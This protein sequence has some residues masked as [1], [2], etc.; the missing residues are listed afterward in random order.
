MTWVSPMPRLGGNRHCRVHPLI[1]SP[2]PSLSPD[3]NPAWV[4]QD[5]MGTPPTGGRL[6]ASRVEFVEP[7]A[8]PAAD[9]PA[10]PRALSLAKSPCREL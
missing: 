7:T 5:T 2:A 4:E 6:L 9:A 10:A 3:Y 1:F 8:P